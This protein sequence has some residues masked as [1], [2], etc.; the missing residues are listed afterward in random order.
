M[1]NREKIMKQ[2]RRAKP[3]RQKNGVLLNSLIL[4]ASVT[5]AIFSV[6]AFVIKQADIEEK[7]ATLQRLTDECAEYEKQNT[8]YSSILSETDERS[9]FERIAI[10]VLGYAYPNERRFYD[11]NNAGK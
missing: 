10:E 1:G 9:Y 4:L 5:V 3:L 2:K 7:Q 8:E 11:S 6:G